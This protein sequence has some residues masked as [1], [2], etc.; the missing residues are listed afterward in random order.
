[1]KKV[2]ERRFGA[3]VRIFRAVSLLSA[4]GPWNDLAFFILATLAFASFVLYRMA[5]FQPFF[6]TVVLYTIAAQVR[7]L[8]L[9]VAL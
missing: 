5:F 9:C 6:V 4:I 3:S 2:K 7:S 1:M 8:F